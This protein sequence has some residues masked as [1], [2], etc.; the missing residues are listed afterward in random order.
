[1]RA[2]LAHTTVSKEARVGWSGEH[3]EKGLGGEVGG[4]FRGECAWL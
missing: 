4:E 3:E 2:R 1:M